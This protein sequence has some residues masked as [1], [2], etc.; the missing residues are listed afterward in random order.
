MYTCFSFKACF[1]LC[2]ILAAGFLSSCEKDPKPGGNTGKDSGEGYLFSMRVL[3]ADGTADFVWKFDSLAELMSG[4]IDVEGKGIEQAGWNYYFG[5]SNALFSVNY[6]D[7]GTIAY[8]LDPQGKIREKGSFFAERLDCMGVADEQH[9]VGVGAPWGGGSVDCEFMVINA[10]NVAISNRRFLPFFQI[11]AGDTLNRWPTGATVR[12][13]KVFVPF[14]P[15]DGESWETP[16]MDSA[17]MNVYSYPEFNYLATL[18]D[19][20]AAPIGMYGSQPCIMKTENGDIYTVSTGSYAS[21][22]TQTGSPSGIL[23]IKNGSTNFDDSYFFNIEESPLAGRLIFGDYL[24]NGKAL[25]RYIAKS[26]DDAQ[27]IVWAATDDTKSCFKVAIIDL[28]SQT[29]TPINIPLH[30][31]EWTRQ[32]YVEDGKIYHSFTFPEQGETRIY[33]IDINTGQAVKG[34]LVKGSTIPLIYKVRY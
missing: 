25:V 31:G 15:L 3:T 26:L 27:Q 29:V 20:R 32:I 30:G 23:R 14:Y 12:D 28:I 19:G 6:G 1:T 34:A 22:Y 8:D 17:Y 16:L 24:G 18:T 11:A 13:G 9:I 10:D 21:G 33:Q 4:E 5:L 2:F 7:E